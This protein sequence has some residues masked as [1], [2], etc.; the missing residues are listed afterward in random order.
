MTQ[1]QIIPMYQGQDWTQELSFY[2]PI[3]DSNPP[4]P[5]YTNP[6]IFTNPFLQVRTQDQLDTLIAQFDIVGL[7]LL[8]GLIVIT[9]P[10]II[11]LSMA[12]ANTTLIPENYY[13]IDLFA[14]TSAGRQPIMQRGVSAL[15]VTQRI[16]EDP[17]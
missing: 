7:G 4:E 17:T 12:H 10:G 5:D 8:G 13:D 3:V 9:A 2:H 15:V 1:P 6:V 11:Q 14:D 16:S